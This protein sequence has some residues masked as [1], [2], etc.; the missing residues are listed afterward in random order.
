MLQVCNDANIG[1][2][3]VG[4]PK[5]V[6]YEP[7]HT[8]DIHI[9]IIS[10]PFTPK[11]L[12]YW[13]QYNVGLPLLKEYNVTA[14]QMYWLAKEQEY[15]SYPKGIGFAY[16][17]WDKYQ[18]YFPKA[19]K[20]RKFRNNWTDICVPGFLQLKYDKP[21]CIVTKAYKDVLCLRSLGYEAISPKSETTMLPE[22][23]IEH[24]KRKYSRIVTLFDN[25]GKH[26]AGEYPFQELH[27]PL[28]TGAKDITDYC[29]M[30]GSQRT[31]ELLSLILNT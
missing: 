26:K 3:K 7:L 19:E 12:N 25:D 14:L 10:K 8:S 29:A 20:S 4:D 16:R 15:P 31:T 9:R 22:L 13:K 28:D 17:I 27:V 18:L 6:E 23:C 2:M 21:L 5:L 1:G 30:Y 24:L 11:E